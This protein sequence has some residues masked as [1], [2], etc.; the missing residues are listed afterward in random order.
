MVL[1]AVI[2]SST[3]LCCPARAHTTENSHRKTTGKATQSFSQKSH[4]L[5]QVACF[6]TFKKDYAKIS[7]SFIW[8]QQPWIW[9]WSNRILGLVSVI[10]VPVHVEWGGGWLWLFSGKCSSCGPGGSS[11]LSF[12]AAKTV[13]E[14]VRQSWPVW[15]L[16]EPVQWAAVFAELFQ[17]YHGVFKA[18]D[19]GTDTVCRCTDF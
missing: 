13:K 4:T 17:S 11:S 9:L 8:H 5:R 7:Q 10:I 16:Q 18:A 1:T 19:A 12:V 3:I 15:Y 2:Q 6:Y 14:T